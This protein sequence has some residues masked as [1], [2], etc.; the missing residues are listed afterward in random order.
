MPFY[1]NPTKNAYRVLQPYPGVQQGPFPQNSNDKLELFGGP[2]WTKATFLALAGRDSS[3]SRE[4]PR[5]SSR[6]VEIF[7]D[8]DRSLEISRDLEQNSDFA[9]VQSR[10]KSSRS[11][12]ISIDTSEPALARQRCNLGSK[13]RSRPLLCAAEKTPR[14]RDGIVVRVLKVGEE[15]EMVALGLNRLVIPQMAASS[16]NPQWFF[17]FCG[18]HQPSSVNPTRCENI[19]MWNQNAFAK[20]T[21]CSSCDWLTY[22]AA[23]PLSPGIS[24][25]LQSISDAV[26]LSLS[27]VAGRVSL[28]RLPSIK[29]SSGYS[30]N[31]HQRVMPWSFLRAQKLVVN[32]GPKRERTIIRGSKLGVKWSSNARFLRYATQLDADLPPME[33][34]ICRTWFAAV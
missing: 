21:G 15:G 11:R 31:R 1:S 33:S 10:I 16:T 20:L 28:S 14:S 30:T 17:E 4:I 29:L 25:N 13:S 12:E 32:V 22:T 3:R 8:L 24:A 26:H 7:R 5:E 6:F 23:S 19:L 2:Y 27:L 9:L 34:L 18:E